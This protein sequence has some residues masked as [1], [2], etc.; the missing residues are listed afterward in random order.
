MKYD[1]DTPVD[2]RGTDCY[3]WDILKDGEL[4][5]WVADMDFKAAPPILEALEKRLRGGVFGDSMIPDRWYDAYIKW[6]GERHGLKM[7]KKDLI[8]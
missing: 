8:F 6:W 4:P 5:M 1:F 3:K 7:E 2:R